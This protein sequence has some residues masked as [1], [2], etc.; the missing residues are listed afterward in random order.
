M[1]PYPQPGRVNEQRPSGRGVENGEKKKK[2][3]NNLR[4]D[5]HDERLGKSNSKRYGC[6]VQNDGASLLQTE[7]ALRA[8]ALGKAKRFVERHSLLFSLFFLLSFQST[9][10]GELRE[11]PAWTAM[12]YSSIMVDAAALV[13]L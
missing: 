2:K 3:K 13:T 7:K 4:I 8:Q 10:G 5:V 11:L 9:N 12:G 1:L 6:A